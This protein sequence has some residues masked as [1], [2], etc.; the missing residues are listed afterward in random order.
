MAVNYKV[1]GQ[2]AP[3][4]T[5]DVTLYGCPALT[6]AVISTISVCNRSTATATFRIAVRPNGATIANQHYLVF[7]A[8]LAANETVA[9]TLGITLNEN[10]V[11]TVRAS[12]A[13]VSFSAFGSEV[14]A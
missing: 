13:N 6:Q 11:L 7:D 9:L 10:D 4:A 5:T 2:A 12:T 1:L 8:A 14:T 3:A